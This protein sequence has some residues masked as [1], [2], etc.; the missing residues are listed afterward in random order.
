MNFSNRRSGKEVLQNVEEAVLSHRLQAS[1]SCLLLFEDIDL[2]F[3]EEDEG[4]HAA[5]AQLITNAV[6]PIVMTTN[7]SMYSP[8]DSKIERKDPLRV[9]FEMPSPSLILKNVLLPIISQM[10]LLM[11][12]QE[13]GAAVNSLVESLVRHCCCDIRLCMNQCQLLFIPGFFNCDT[14]HHHIGWGS[15]Y[16]F[17]FVRKSF[18]DSNN[19]L[20]RDVK[21]S[22]RDNLDIDVLCNSKKTA[23]NR[24][25]ELQQG[26]SLLSDVDYIENRL[27]G[28]DTE[29]KETISGYFRENFNSYL[30]SR[31]DSCAVECFGSLALENDADLVEEK[32][33]EELKAEMEDY[34]DPGWENWAAV[35]SIVKASALNSVG[36][37][38]KR[39]GR[40]SCYFNRLHQSFVQRICNT[41]SF[42]T[43]LE[44]AR[45]LEE[46][47]S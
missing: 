41:L 9:H 11:E 10:S 43:E 34:T 39:N 20:N 21:R 2:L 4:F 42:H 33:V 25:I 5:V 45:E 15:P 6:R 24:L 26:L 29:D 16:D 1:E 22:S 32:G 44:I 28:Y 18:S 23:L 47:A 35:R 3:A 7:C 17:N 27:S 19:S 12:K 38:A 30:T 8:L 31:Q 46:T 13:S 14:I 37:M 40:L 36:R